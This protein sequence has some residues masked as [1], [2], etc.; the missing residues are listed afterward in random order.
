MFDRFTDDA[1]RALN[2]AR[3]EAFRL[4]HGYIG[5]EHL[6]LGV[7]DQ[8]LPFGTKLS[9]ALGVEPQDVVATVESIVVKGDANTAALG[10]L[11]FTP[12]ATRVLE[13][14]ME[15]AT[16]LGDEWL[17][18]QHFFLGMIREGEGIAGHVLVGEGL[19]LA[20][21]RH[22]VREHFAESRPVPSRTRPD[23]RARLA[24]AALILAPV[25]A[26]SG[27]SLHLSG[28]EQAAHLATWVSF[29]CW[30]PAVLCLEHFLKKVADRVGG[31]ANGLGL[32]GALL[33]TNAVAAG[34]VL[35]AVG[36]DPV[37]GEVAG[38]IPELIDG[39]VV[40]STLL[41][42]GALLCFGIGYAR[43]RLAPVWVGVLLGMGAMCWLV[44]AVTLLAV[45]GLA[46]ALLQVLPCAWMGARLI[47]QPELWGGPFLEDS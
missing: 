35:D 42:C 24:G 23:Y 29:A 12:G 45:V 40:L 4:G 13:F 37:A 38:L 6:A 39:A 22:F 44:G 5:T 3:E 30:I 2:R 31:L 9:G 19:T 17:G 11:P 34:W 15:E 18:P 36:A 8:R 47:Q 46:G 32:T 10:S 43:C 14:S 16:E 26:S 1:K 41:L 33:G 28:R 25:C 27:L 20:G 7:L 21:A